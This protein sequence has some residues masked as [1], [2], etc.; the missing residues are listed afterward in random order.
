MNLHRTGKGTQDDWNHQARRIVVIG[1]GIGAMATGALFAKCGHRIQVLERHPE[2]I[3]G[4]AR[5]P[6]VEGLKFSMGPQYVWR[7]NPGDVGDRFLR[8]LGIADKT[9]FLPM[10]P[11]S[12]ETHFVGPQGLGQGTV[13]FEVPMGLSR[14]RD[15]LLAE[16]PDDRRGLTRLFDDMIELYRAYTVLSAKHN[17]QDAWP[18]KL[19]LAFAPEVSLSTKAKLLRLAFQTL[20]RWFDRYGISPLVRRILYGHSGIFLENESEMSAIVFVVGT[21][22]YHAGARYPAHGFDVFLDTLKQ[23]IEAGGGAVSVGKRVTRIE[24]DQGLTRSV[25]CAD[26]SSYPCDAVFSDISPRLTAAALS[27]PVANGLKYEPSHSTIA[28]CIGLVGRL[29]SVRALRGRNYWYQEGSGEVDYKNVDLTRPPQMIF[30]ASHTANG[31][32]RT[33]KNPED[34][35]LTA[36]IAGN[37]E[38]E[39]AIY[40]QGPQAVSRWKDKLQQDLVSILDRAVLPGIQAHIR[41]VRIVSTIDLVEETGSERGS[42]YGRR[43][44]VPEVLRGQPADLPLANLY[45]VSS[46]QNGPGISSGVLTGTRLLERL[47]GISV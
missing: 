21:G 45:N 1:S 30:L 11:D 28:A 19:A 40:A 13:R 35:S 32:G 22:H 6:V 3:G 2:L 4:Q 43:L 42:V 39:R 31:F 29:E 24:V 37:F 47:T 9:P 14:F 7:F 26:G 36:Y 25:T 20:E 5:H 27:A 33:E 15:R 17:P 18:A 16:F 44:T 38:Q 12:F 23:V 8:F 10:D 34:D 46:T 41:F